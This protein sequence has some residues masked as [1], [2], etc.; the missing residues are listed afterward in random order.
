MV[1]RGAGRASH[2]ELFE[3]WDRGVDKGMSVS[4]REEEKGE[5]ESEMKELKNKEENYTGVRAIFLYIMLLGCIFVLPQGRRASMPSLPKH[6]IPYP[7]SQHLLAPQS[8]PT[9]YSSPH[10]FAA[11]LHLHTS[12]HCLIPAYPIPT[13]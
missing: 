3:L 9:L 12:F 4:L 8:T 2:D 13:H 10:A 6:G 1:W 5:L 11:W 7:A